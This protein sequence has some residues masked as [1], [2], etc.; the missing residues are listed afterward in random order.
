MA[1]AKVNKTMEEAELKSLEDFNRRKKKAL[2]EQADL[3][4]QEKDLERAKTEI[5]DADPD[6]E[7]RATVA[8]SDQLADVLSGLQEDGKF[9]VFR[10]DE[11]GR[12][13]QVG[14]YPVADWPVRMEEI[15]HQAGGGT[16]KI[17]FKTS[18][19]K[20]VK[21]TTQTFDP[22]FYGKK[23]SDGARADGGIMQA[24]VEMQR[25]NT[26]TMEASR[27]DMLAMMQTMIT[28]MSGK[29]NSFLSSAQDIAVIGELFKGNKS[30]G[31]AI[32]ALK[33]GIELGMRM[34]EGKEPPSTLDKVLES[35][36]AP[37]AGLLE[38]LSAPRPAAPAAPVRPAALPRPVTEPPATAAP[39]V[40]AV[41][42]DPVKEHP[43]YRTYVPKILDAA[44]KGEDPKEW[45]EYICD[46]V[47]AMY[48]PKL[49]EIVQKPDLVEFLG[50]YEIEARDQAVWIVKTRDEILA[51]F[52]PED[53]ADNP[54]KGPMTKAPEG[55]QIGDRSG[56]IPPVLLDAMAG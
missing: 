48:H 40:P 2:E 11:Q 50:S 1:K 44:K 54:P 17:Q 30:E 53:V 35:I 49:L 29:Q 41:P 28:A 4:R 14:A 9:W 42:V 22:K 26:A 13:Y 27:R 15:A 19:G 38:R 37:A 10:I 18:D 43:F 25:Q 34:G 45:A 23:E 8:I 31:G 39:P 36:A 47:P 7:M 52:P 20:F 16:F 3:L 5:D 33:T 55:V 51:L 46:M 56:D 24:V 6:A 21:Q 12:S 32:E